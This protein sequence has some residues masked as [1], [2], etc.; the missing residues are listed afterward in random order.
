[1]A[2][3]SYYQSHGWS[4]FPIVTNGKTPAIPAWEPYQTVP[5]APPVIDDWSR[6][7]SNAGVATGAVSG[8]FVFDLDGLVAWA[9]AHERGLPETLT[10]KT[11]RGWHYYYKH[12]GWPVRNRAGLRDLP[13]AD[14]TRGT[15]NDG[16]DIR[17]DG[18]YVVGPGSWYEPTADERAAGKLP[19][20]YVV[21]CD[22]PVADAPDWLLQMLAQSPVAPAAPA[23]YRVAEQTSAY[24][25]NALHGELAEIA[26]ATSGHVNDQINLSVFAIAQLTAGGEI[27]EEEARGSIDEALAARG[28]GDEEKTLGTVE[29]A[30]LAGIQL[31]RAAPDHSPITVFGARESLPGES[32]TL[33]PNDLQNIGPRDRPNIIVG[34][35][36]IEYFE[37]CVYIVRDNTIYVPGAPAGLGQSQFNAIYGGPKFMLSAEGTDPTKSAWECFTNNQIVPLPRVWA[38]CFRPELPTRG[39]VQIEGL[40]YLNTYVPAVVPRKQGDPTPFTDFLARLLPDERDRQILLSYAAAL[41]QNPGRKFQW[42]PV[43][44]GAEGNG[45][46]AMLQCISKAV[47]ERYTHLVNPEAMAKTGNQFNSWIQGNLFLGI[48]EI[49]MASR[50]DFLDSFKPVVTNSR[51]GL[52]GKGKDQSTGDNRLNGLLCTNHRDAIPITVDGRRYAIFYTAQQSAADIERDFPD[53]YFVKFY[54]WLNADGFAI[55]AEYLH[56][57]EPVAE[58]NP[59]GRCQRAPRTSSTVAALGEGHGM[60][61]Q[62]VLEAI[63]S[64]VFGFRGGIVSSVALGRLFERLR[65]KISPNRY[66]PMMRSLGY[67]YHPSLHNGRSTVRLADQSK[68]RFYF[69]AGHA[70]LDLDEGSLIAQAYEDAQNLSDGPGGN[71]IPLRR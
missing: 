4:L 59:A 68:P 48:E 26:E 9:A 14:G 62:E 15:R 3:W 16:W 20:G 55:V 29:R 33:P 43:L 42:W 67:S 52:E 34:S 13:A 45:K 66:L 71:V 25:R 30:W 19:G 69:K 38:T 6:Q 35:R 24:G 18:G 49:H 51:I 60:V 58:F 40:L 8:V 12:P 31:P 11:P 65:V 70:A 36:I 27:T 22:A 61:E 63:D 54:D 10:V 5:A 64:E 50:R 41:V 47:G 53:D 56:T 39:A 1:M 21:E 44:Q 32:V 46:S 2:D 37:G 57:F 17:G 23:P 7:Y 28:I